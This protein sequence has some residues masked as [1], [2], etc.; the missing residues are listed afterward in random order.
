MSQ[1]QPEGA[2][3]TEA[4]M[5]AGWGCVL[6]SSGTHSLTVHADLVPQVAHVECRIANP[7]REYKAATYS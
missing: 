5:C 2:E 6:G 1:E 7:E 3:R 4:G